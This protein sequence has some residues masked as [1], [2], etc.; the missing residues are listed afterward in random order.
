MTVRFPCGAHSW[1][2]LSPTAAPA[3]RS[4]PC[5]HRCNAARI[6]P[7]GNT[8]RLLTTRPPKRSL[9]GAPS[10]IYTVSLGRASPH[11]G[12]GQLN[13]D[14]ADFPGS[15]RHATIRSWIDA[16]IRINAQATKNSPPTTA[17][18]MP[19][20]YRPRLSSPVNTSLWPS[21]K[22]SANAAPPAM[23]STSILGISKNRLENRTRLLPR[24]R[25]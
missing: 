13:H 20:Q 5:P 7:V 12:E 16:L 6:C 25:S 21:Q 15:F 8:G 4:L 14:Q 11:F 1:R 18:I 19:L 3:L 24:L 23:A 10:G 2:T 17:R 22:A 9:D